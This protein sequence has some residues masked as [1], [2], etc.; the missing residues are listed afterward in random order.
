MVSVEVERGRAEHNDRWRAQHR[1][2]L[3]TKDQGEQ[4]EHSDC[5]ARDIREL[6]ALAPRG[7]VD[8]Q[9]TALEDWKAISRFR[10][11]LLLFSFYG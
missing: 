10:E 7:L 3:G 9:Q 4:P 11:S 6:A 2:R 5:A 8:K 1:Q